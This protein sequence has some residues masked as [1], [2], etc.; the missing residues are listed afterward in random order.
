[1][2]K[3]AYSVLSGSRPHAAK[4]QRINTGKAPDTEG[5]DTIPIEMCVS[6]E[7]HLIGTY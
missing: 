4:K 7:A 2:D 3:K 1:M 5:Q 6:I